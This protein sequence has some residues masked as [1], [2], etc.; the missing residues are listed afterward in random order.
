MSF[1]GKNSKSSNT[2]GVFGEVM[3]QGKNDA[4]AVKVS[5]IFYDEKQNKDLLVLHNC[6]RCY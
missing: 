4:N 6:P 5:A 3:N 1:V 2:F